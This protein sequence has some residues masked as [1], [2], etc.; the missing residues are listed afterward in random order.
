MEERGVL[1]HMAVS[2]LEVERE[3]QRQCL[4]WRGAEEAVWQSVCFFTSHLFFHRSEDLF[5]LKSR[6][7]PVMLVESLFG[8]NCSSFLR[9][10]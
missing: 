2:L 6:E 7:K 4:H 3:E 10:S 5:Y 8:S 1:G 9:V